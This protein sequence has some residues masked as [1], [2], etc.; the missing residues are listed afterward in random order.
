MP[1]TKR[2]APRDPLHISPDDPRRSRLFPRGT[3]L[4]LGLLCVGTL[5]LVYPGQRLMQLLASSPDNTLAIDYLRHLVDLRGGDIDLRL[6]LAQR[7]ERIGRQQQALDT[8]GNLQSPQADALRLKIWKTRW[9]DARALGHRAEEAQA[10]QALSALLQRTTPTRFTEWRDTLLLLQGLDEPKAV[11]RLAAMV[12][13][14][15]PL[16]PAAAMQA[17]QLLVGLHADALAAQVLFDTAKTQVTDAERQTLLQAGARALLASGQPKLAYQR[18]AAAMQGLKPAPTMAWFMVQLA[19][20]ANQPQ[21]A[22]LWLRQA[23]DL[24]QPA[25]QLGRALTPAQRELAWQ[26]LLA[27]G[28]LAGAVRMAD[29]A[30]AQSPDRA[31]AERRAQVLEWSGKPDAAMQQWIALLRAQFSQHALDE[32]RRL[33]L[34]LHSSSGMDVYW[35]Q[36]A[37][38]GTLLTTDEWLQYAQA[39]EVRGHPEQAVRILR[40]ASAKEPGVLTALAW[41]LGNMGEV[42]AS[43][44]TYAQALQRGSLDL[45]GSIDY[46]IALLQ[47]GQF[48][49]ARQVLEATQRLPGADDLR[50]THQG[51]LGDIAWDMGESRSAEE[52]YDSIWQSLALRD[53][54]KPYQLQRL[55]ALVQKSQGDAAALRLLPQAWA[56]SPSEALGLLWLQSLVRQPSLQGIDTWQRMV[57]GSE[58]GA[59]LRHD[60]Q[61]YAARAQVWRGLGRTDL[62]LADLRE[63]LRLDPRNTD[64]QIA[65]LW[66][67]ID[68]NQLDALRQDMALYSRS[69]TGLPEGLDVLSAAAQTVGDTAAALR[70]SQPLYPRK[71]SD[72]LWL[73]NYGDL[74]AQAGDSRRARAAYDQSWRLLQRPSAAAPAAA[75]GGTDRTLDPLLARLRLSHGRLDGAGQQ[76]LLAQLRDKLHSGTLNAQQTLQANAAIADWLLRLDTDSAARWWLAR[77]VLTPAARQ[78]IELQMALREGDRETVRRLLQQGAA[79]HLLPQ[80]R[81]E[82]ERIAGHP[83]QSLAEAEQVLEQAAER[84]QDNPALQGLA[85]QTAEQQLA[86]AHRATLT[87]EHRQIDNVVR[88]G[89]VLRLSLQLSGQWRVQ[90]QA[91]RQAMHSNNTEALVGVPSTWNDAQ[92][93]LQWQ[94]ERSRLGGTLSHNTAVGSLNGWRL[95]GSTRLPGQIEAQVQ[96]EY[97]AVADE[98]GPLQIAG[99]RDRL[100]LRLSRDFGRVWANVSTAVMSYDTRRGNPLGHGTSTQF[101]LGLWLRRQEPDLSVKLLGY[102]NRFSANAGPPLPD[103]AP[104]VPGGGAPTAA[105]FM[106]AGDDVFGLGLGFNMAHGDT[107]TRRWLPYAEVD[108]LQSRRLGLTNNLNLGIHGPLFGPDELSFSYQRQQNTS[109]LNRQWNLQYRLWFGR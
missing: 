5:A 7:Y 66:M 12:T 28:D 101:E 82:A 35:E 26:V 59:P 102:S 14:F 22:V 3:L 96:A 29:A 104:L 92:F 11:Q 80:D 75:K 51:L 60:A 98:S 55:I 32:L 2:L 54:I 23:V 47:S 109:G 63:A 87:M 73:L 48:A 49:Q 33:A 52:A 62:A 44:S 31:W 38:R 42:E 4:G 79:R 50:A 39:L 89:P 61:M 69:L 45:R 85:R 83:M 40:Q 25:P 64:N 20:G 74:L 72:A 27:G 94:G 107:Y 18:T 95:D 84:G 108:V 81:A 15:L 86:L 21:N 88:Q 67:L 9:F 100:Q 70:Y 77:R 36:R 13:H 103:Y 34:A 90:A 57:L 1:D 71:K 91:S 106:P 41:L 17:A 97:H 56:R 30:L 58:A 43:L 6:M 10:R 76:A 65:L 105:F 16:P 68:A 99:S 53:R 78:S 46:A 37:A 93:G 24:D 19:L 8:L